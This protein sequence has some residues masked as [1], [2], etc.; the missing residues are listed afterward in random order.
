MRRR[1]GSTIVRVRRLIVWFRRDL[2]I[3]DHEA[4]WHACRD[5]G[6]VVPLF[7][8]DPAHF[9]NREVGSGRVQFLLDSLR[10]LD[11]SLR[12]RGS[13]LFLAR[14]AAADVLPRAV[15][16][17]QTDGVYFSADIERWSGQV[18]DRE[19]AA[20]AA[21]Q[22]W[23]FKAHVNFHL[24]T[25]GGFD[26]D[27]WH[28]AWTEHSK[29][30]VRRA[31]ERIVTPG[32]V[33]G[34][35]LPRFDAVPSLA[36]L[37]LPPNQQTVLPGGEQAAR[38]RLRDFLDRRVDAYRRS[39][40]K[41]ILAED[42]GTSRMSA[43]FK[44]GC[45]SQRET[46]QAA[47][48]RYRTASAAGQKGLEAWVSRLR[49]RDHF[50]QKFALYPQAEFVNLYQPF[51]AIRRVE[52][53]DPGRLDAWRFGMTGYPLIDASMRSL[54][55]T[56]LL[57]FRMRAML[58]TFLSLNLMH[59]WQ[60][61]AEWFMKHLLDGDA[62]VDHWQWQMQAGITQPSRAFI[63]CY[64]PTKQCFDNDPD[65][66]FI[67]KYV[68]EL[69]AVPAPL[70]FTPWRMTAMEQIMYGVSI[71]RDYPAPI[72]DADQSRRAALDVVQPI[73]E[74]LATEA[75]L[76]LLVNHAAGVTPLLRN[77]TVRQPLPTNA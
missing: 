54:R 2:R 40:S 19:L 34:A 56:G 8:L 35:D 18:R 70:V 16:S 41:P 17:W 31:P 72:V 36:E 24:Q 3:H 49:W 21:T 60:H 45:V 15:R 10:D 4:L 51:D 68:P 71:G 47:R 29:S 25:H 26:R 59:A 67:H 75:D 6:E 62:A 32:P 23:T 61:G 44:F 43:Y 77:E 9:A 37:G 57:N 50:V 33:D 14:G 66:R 13:R 55:Q 48:A 52:D 27:R 5:A 28:A 42:D 11:D 69:R 38:A 58:A 64:N 39:I 53:V 12:Q 1:R 20:V 73:R 22:G 46:V 30:P 74:R 76:D 65:A 63:R 7:I